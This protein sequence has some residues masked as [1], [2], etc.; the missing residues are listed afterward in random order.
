MKI[1]KD[2]LESL[3]KINFLTLS[4]PVISMKPNSFTPVIGIQ[5]S[6][7]V[8]DVQDLKSLGITDDLICYKIGKEIKEHIEK[9]N[10]S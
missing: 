6:F 9:R 5:I 1:D 10:K 7:S 8:E 2:E 3:E 4:D